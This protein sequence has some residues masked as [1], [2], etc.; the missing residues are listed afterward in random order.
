MRESVRQDDLIEKILPERQF[1]SLP[2]WSTWTPAEAASWI[3]SNVTDLAS[4]KVVLKNM[5]RAIV[6]LRSLILKTR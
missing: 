3:D 5:A 2:G 6:L 4:A 1:R